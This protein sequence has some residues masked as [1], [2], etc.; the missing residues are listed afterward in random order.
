MDLRVVAGSTWRDPMDTPIHN[1]I[2]T[3]NVITSGRNDNSTMDLDIQQHNLSSAQLQ[4][5]ISQY[6]LSHQNDNED[7]IER[8]YNE[9]SG[10][11]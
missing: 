11:N 1:D 9:S 8:R 6:Q 4:S 7:N 10:G 2:D 3:N 5:P